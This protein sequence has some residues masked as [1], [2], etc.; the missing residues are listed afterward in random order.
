MATATNTAAANFPN[1]VPQSV[2]DDSRSITHVTGWDASSGGNDLITID[3]TDVSLSELGQTIRI[4]ASMITLTQP[5]IAYNSSG[6]EVGRISADMAERL[7][8]GAIKDGIWWQA[9]YGNPGTDR[10]ANA[11]TELGR[12][13]IGESAWTVAQ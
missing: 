9:H 5:E 12:C 1:V 8:R 7:I 3:I 4:P 11:L 10:T 6:T 13:S 2:I